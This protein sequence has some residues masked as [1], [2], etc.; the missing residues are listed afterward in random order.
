MTSISQAPAPLAILLFPLDVGPK[1][2]H[3]CPLLEGG[4]RPLLVLLCALQVGP[5]GHGVPDLLHVLIVFSVAV[6]AAD[7]IAD[8][9]DRV[10]AKG[11][12]V[13]VP[14][15]GQVVHDAGARPG[16]DAVHE[17]VPEAERELVI[18]SVKIMDAVID[19]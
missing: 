7:K 5:A 8:R 16:R 12:P 6:A 11:E 19:R 10:H 13:G 14:R 1:V 15:G 17:A 4:R 3:L 18:Y 2:P 9:D